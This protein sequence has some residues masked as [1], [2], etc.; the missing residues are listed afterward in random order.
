MA[1]PIFIQSFA[2]LE[3]G[4]CGLVSGSTR[5]RGVDEVANH[6]QIRFGGG[7]K[8]AGLRHLVGNIDVASLRRCCEKSFAEL[9]IGGAVPGFCE[10]RSHDWIKFVSVGLVARGQR[11]ITGGL[12]PQTTTASEFGAKSQQI[13]ARRFPAEF[14]SER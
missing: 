13:G 9:V 11:S 3:E 6:L 7:K 1:L 2:D 5:E 8:Q 12:L 10:E 14:R 4:N